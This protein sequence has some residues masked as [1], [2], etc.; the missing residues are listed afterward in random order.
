MFRK[1]IFVMA[2]VLAAVSCSLDDGGGY[3]QSFREFATFE[4]SSIDYEDTFGSDSVYFDTDYGIGMIWSTLIF[5]HKVTDGEF[6]GG[7]ALSYL[8]SRGEGADT[9]GLDNTFRVNATA[10]KSSKTYMV[11][12]DNPEPDCM[13]EHSLYFNEETYGTCSMVGCMVNNTVRVKD[14]I[15]VNFVAGDKLVVKATGYLDG[16][17]TGTAEFLLAERTTQKDSVVSAWTVFDMRALG[18][19]DNVDFEVVSTAAGI[20]PYFCLDNLQ[21]DVTIT[22]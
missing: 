22:Y 21:A 9:L 8:K 20:P 12:Y 13:P 14:S 3:S 10:A 16:V 18:E 1:I 15:L 11:F 19:V 4:Y 7:F 5:Q 2:V 17:K 6:K